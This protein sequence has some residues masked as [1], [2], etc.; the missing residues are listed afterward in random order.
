MSRLIR[1]A[2]IIG[3]LYLVLLITDNAQAAINWATNTAMGSV[4]VL[5]AVTKVN[6]GGVD[7]FYAVGGGTSGTACSNGTG[8]G[9]VFFTKDIGDG[10]LGT[11]AETGGGTGNF[12]R[13]AAGIAEQNGYIYIA[14]GAIN[15]PSWDGNV[16]YTKPNDL[17]GTIASWTQST[18]AMPQWIGSFPY[19][20]AYNGYLYVGGGRNA[21]GTPYKWTDRLYYSQLNP[22]TGLPGP[23]QTATALPSVT[24]AGEGALVFY[25]AKAYLILGRTSDSTTSDKVYYTTVSL[26]TGALGAWT[27]TTPLPYAVSQVHASFFIENDRLYVLMNGTDVYYSKVQPDGSLGSWI[28]DTSLPVALTPG[29]AAVTSGNI[30]Y[31]VGNYNCTGSTTVYYGKGSLGGKISGQVK[32]N[33]EKA[34]GGVI[35]KL[36]P[37]APDNTMIKSVM[38]NAQGQFVFDNLASGDYR[39]LFDTN[40]FTPQAY[41]GKPDLASADNVSVT[42]PNETTL[43]PSLLLLSANDRYIGV[44]KTGLGT[45][46]DNYNRINCGNICT[47]SYDSGTENKVTLHFRPASGYYVNTIKIDPPGGLSL[48]GVFSLTFRGITNIGQT[49]LGEF[50]QP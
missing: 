42:S 3:F 16:W 21:F 24:G 14:G 23:W 45:I 27:E 9:K 34:I 25:N 17:D 39:V 19:V 44:V 33:L 11:W 32:D 36:Y 13:V 2:G 20:A 48:G 1:I 10:V 41:N 30:Y 37:P 26:T 38:T 7:Y 31:I 8:D 50:S 12:I 18:N 5:P 35:V 47:A 46:V 29:K 43:N 49:V 40:G 15:S 6:I 4:R 22:A 28:Q